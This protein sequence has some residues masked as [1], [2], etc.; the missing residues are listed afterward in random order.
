MLSQARIN[1]DVGAYVNKKYW[2]QASN[3]LRRQVG[4]LRFDIN[5]LVAEKGGDSAAAKAFYKKL[6]NL[7]FSIR[8]KD[9][10]AATALL[11]DVQAT[12]NALIGSLA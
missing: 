3:E 10:A 4:T 1:G 8:Q 5:N 6:E 12:A 11:A 7:D 9:Q 2:T